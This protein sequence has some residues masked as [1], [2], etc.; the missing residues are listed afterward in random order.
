[1]AVVPGGGHT[2]AAVAHAPL[3]PLVP[4]HDDLPGAGPATPAPGA[5][6]VRASAAPARGP[7][8]HPDHSGEG[9]PGDRPNMPPQ[10]RCRGLPDGSSSRGSSRGSTLFTW[11]IVVVGLAPKLRRARRGKRST[12]THKNMKPCT[13]GAQ[14]GLRKGGGSRSL[15]YGRALPTCLLAE[16]RAA[17]PV[18]GWRCLQDAALGLDVREGRECLG[19]LGRQQAEMAV[20]KAPKD[21]CP[22]LRHV[23]IAMRGAVVTKAHARNI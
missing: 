10:S 19:N 11:L 15:P 3:A 14:A 20:R 5:G 22:S 21:G 2:T 7:A 8:T 9:H 4:P 23:S 12:H 13:T 6:L 1:V 17:G 16:A 18:G